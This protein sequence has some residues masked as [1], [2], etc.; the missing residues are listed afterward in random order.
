MVHVPDQVQGRNPN[1]VNHENELERATLAASS[2]PGNRVVVFAGTPGAGKTATAVEFSFRV[3]DDFPDGRLFGRLSSSLKQDGA[4][5][6]VLGDF[7]YALGVARQDVPDRL[8]ARRARY[9]EMTAGR[10]LQVLLDGAMSASQVRTLLPGDGDSLI[11]VTEGRPLPTLAVDTP[12][13]V[14]E[15]SPFTDDAARELLVRLLDS[16]RVDAEPDAVTEVVTLCGHLPIALCVVGAMMR[17][18]PSRTFAGMAERLRDERR[19]IATLSRDVDLSVDA[20]F[21]TAYRTLSDLAQRC[22]L[23][24]GMR[25]RSGQLSVDALAATL[26]LP[27]DDVVDGM[28]DLVVARLVDEVADNR[29]TVRELIQLHAEQL[30]KRPADER[31]AENRR[32][33][34][35]YHRRVVDAGALVAPARPWRDVLFPDLAPTGEFSDAAA[36]WGWLRSERANLLA[37]TGFLADVGEFDRVVQWCVLLWP[38]YEKDKCFADLFATHRFGLP[39]ARRLSSAP[40]ESLLHSQVGFAHYW[41]RDLDEAAKE[42]EAAVQLA[43]DAASLELE[44][45]ALE[46]LGLSELERGNISLARETLRRNLELARQIRDQRRIALAAL[47]GAKVEEPTTALALLAEADDQFATRGDDEVENRAKVSTWRGKKLVELGSWAEAEA[48]LLSAL[49]VM[50]ARG[51][52]FDQAEILVALGDLAAGRGAR[53]AALRHY[54]EALVAYEDLCFTALAAAVRAKIIGLGQP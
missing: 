53:D 54:R 27:A 41:V 46:G 48:A 24:L 4:E 52:R 16:A 31:E 7:L 38:F 6:D 21:T 28:D 3:V 40:V 49:D 17:R 23:A 15:L 35:F 37:A 29:F 34:G 39:A 12:V 43:K 2:G 50:S 19:R 22:Y 13:T 25:P 18:S 1:Y 20:A 33:I 10:R 51:R 11:L 26:D 44:A 47:H 9:Q 5:T 30:D 42:F 45:T 32:L 8:D 36:A 14:L